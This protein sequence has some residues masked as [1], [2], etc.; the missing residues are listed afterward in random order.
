MNRIIFTFF[1]LI[2]FSACKKSEDV[3]PEVEEVPNMTVSVA[4]LTDTPDDLS[5]EGDATYSLLGYGYD[6]TNKYA[7][8]TSVRAS[9]IDVPLFVANNYNGAFSQGWGTQGFPVILNATSAADFSNQLSS[10]YDETKGLTVFKST[11]TSAFPE[12]DVQ[13]KKYGYGYFSGVF[14]AR[15]LRLDAEKVGNNLSSVFTTD[16]KNLSPE[17]LVKKY[18]THILMRIQLGSRINILYQAE[19]AD[20]PD[21][22]L[23]VKQ[24]LDYSIR[25]VFGF[26]PG[27]LPSV[28]AKAINLNSSVKLRYEVI[29]GDPR[30]I[31]ELTIAGRTMVDF[32][33][34]NSSVSPENYKFI[35]FDTNGLKPLSDIIADGA[36]KALVQAYIK[37]YIAENQ[38]KTN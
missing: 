21:K 22:I 17:Q 37:N 18:G 7:S 4:K 27:F 24:G 2:M 9:V 29:G 15:H 3:I 11:I 20:G 16:L 14:R 31:K 19:V 12:S 6:I 30:K 26:S 36:K 32:N 34:W 28:D 10:K 13:S 25:R 33:E 8:K 38:V 5:T 35:D 23:A 1:L